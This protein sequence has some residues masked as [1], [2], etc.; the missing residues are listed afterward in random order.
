VVRDAVPLEAID[1]RSAEAPNRP[2]ARRIEEHI[3]AW[4]AE[5]PATDEPSIETPLIDGPTTD[6]PT[7]VEPP[8]E[9]PVAEE[10]ASECQPA[11][12]PRETP[13]MARPVET[14]AIA[15]PEAAREPSPVAERS[16]PNVDD[17]ERQ[18]DP[19]WVAVA[20]LSPPIRQPAQYGFNP[21]MSLTQ[22][23]RKIA[24]ERV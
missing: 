6:E 12:E 2:A 23:L 5:R 4:P 13:S 8:T 1:R 19:A 22:T 17:L 10:P 3:A 16:P 18:F 9:E 14:I 21:R 7:S 15:L 11:E 24:V 20:A